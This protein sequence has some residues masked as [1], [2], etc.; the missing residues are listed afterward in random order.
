MEAAYQETK[1]ELEARQILPTASLPMAPP[2]VRTYADDAADRHLPESYPPEFPP[3]VDL[4]EDKDKRERSHKKLTAYFKDR[5][6]GRASPLD[7][8]TSSSD[9][10]FDSDSEYSQN[11][12][13]RRS[14]D[15]RRW[16][17]EKRAVKETYHL[18]S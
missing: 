13:Y 6:R 12:R 3:H 18:D 10:S 5:P 8:S 17:E 9:S 7:D 16:R 15:K 11:R 14:K 4:P 2:P 1:R